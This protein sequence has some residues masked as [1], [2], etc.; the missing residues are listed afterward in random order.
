VPGTPK[1]FSKRQTH[2]LIFAGALIVF[3]TFIVKEGLRDYWRETAEAIDTAQ[4]IYSLKTKLSEQDAFDAQLV[5]CNTPLAN[6][7]ASMF[8]STNDCENLN[9]RSFLE[10]L[11]EVEPS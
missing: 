1:T 7:S 6:A 9:G 11:R 3:S 8:K 2:L 5:F 4:Y 10:I